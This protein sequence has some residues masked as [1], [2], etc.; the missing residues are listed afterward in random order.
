[1]NELHLVALHLRHAEV[2]EVGVE[3]NPNGHS[4]MVSNRVHKLPSSTAHLNQGDVFSTKLDLLRNFNNEL[5]GL[6]TE[7][8]KILSRNVYRVPPSLNTERAPVTT[9]RIFRLP[10]WT[11]MDRL[12]LCVK[13]PI[14][15][16]LVVTSD[17][18]NVMQTIGD[19]VCERILGLSSK[20]DLLVSW[21]AV[22]VARIRLHVAAQ[23]IC[24]G[25]EHG[26][27]AGQRFDLVEYT[28]VAG[29]QPSTNTIR[30]F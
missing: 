27:A 10:N 30:R 8:T 9:T 24:H 14:L 13:R 17:D 11:N 7:F 2:D 16:P 25:E 19:G 12:A 3:V 1:M 6:F 15:K 22:Q 20:P 5:N 28:P 18:A 23:H 4:E 26:L 29:K 21:N